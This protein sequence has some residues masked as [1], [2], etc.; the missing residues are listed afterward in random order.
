MG[1]CVDDTIH[2]LY[3]FQHSYNKDGRVEEALQEAMKHAGKAILITSLL[4]VGCMGIYLI[5][6]LLSLRRFGLL[7]IVAV[8]F[9]VLSDFLLAPILIRFMYRDR[10]QK[11]I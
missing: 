8:F 7:M 5:S 1:I 6:D 2:F 4:L 11:N 3:H 9:A 10:E